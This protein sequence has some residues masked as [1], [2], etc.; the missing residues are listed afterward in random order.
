MVIIPF[1]KL[2]S[3]TIDYFV[4]SAESQYLGTQAMDFERLKYSEVIGMKIIPNLKCSQLQI[5]MNQCFVST[6]QD[7]LNILKII[8]EMHIP[9]IRKPHTPSAYAEQTARP[10]FRLKSNPYTF[11]SN[12]NLYYQTEASYNRTYTEMEKTNVFLDAIA[13][14]TRYTKAILDIRNLLPREISDNVPPEYRLGHIADTICNHSLVEKGVDLD[15]F[16]GEAT[17]PHIKLTYAPYDDT[18]AAMYYINGKEKRLQRPHV[19]CTAC[20]Q[21]DHEAKSCNQLAKLS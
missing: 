18:E 3:S 4:P 11:Q 9:R 5:T 15:A 17:Q 2:S 10:T 14:D 20:K 8:L 19:Q 16:Y 12:L 13:N 7:G 6:H 21:Y 1:A